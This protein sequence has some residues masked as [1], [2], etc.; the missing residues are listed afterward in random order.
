M[1]ETLESA[2]GFAAAGLAR[3]AGQERGYG[4]GLPEH[5]VKLPGED[6]ALWRCAALR[7]AGF[8]AARVL[9][10]AR[11]AC[12]ADADELLDA[13]ETAGPARAEALGAVNAELDALR[14]EAGWDDKTKRAPL[15][16]ALRLL[17]EGKQPRA[18]GL[19]DAAREALERLRAA[20]ERAEALRDD[21][22]RSYGRAVEE[23][24]LEINRTLEEPRFREAVIWQNRRAFHAGMQSLLRNPPGAGA[25]TFKRRQ[26]EEL[27]ANDL[28]RY[29]VKNDT[30]GFFGPVGWARLASSGEPVRLETGDGLLAARNVYFEGWCID[31][32]ADKLAARA[33]MRPWAAP[34]RVPYMRLEGN[35]L[36]LPRT[37]PLPLPPKYAAVLAACDGRLSA[38]EIAAGLKRTPSLGFRAEAEVYKILTELVGKGLISWTFEIPLE[39]HPEETLRRRLE[40][41]ADESLRAV[42]LSELDELDEARREVARAA[43]DAARLDEA[44]GR[45]EET[46]AR[47]TDA[48]TT[49]DAGKTYAGRTLIYEDCLRD[50]RAEVGPEIVDALGGPLS[51][52]LTSARWLTFKVAELCLQTLGE[53]YEEMAR[54]AASP[55]V[56]AVSFWMR[57][58]P[59]LFAE[60]NSLLRTAERLFQERWAGVLELPPDAGR[61]AY[62]CER[63]RPR[64]LKAFDAPRPGWKLARYHCPDLMIAADDLEAVRRGDYRLVVGELHVGL[65]TLG[66]SLFLSQHPRPAE[67]F[68]ALESDF[69]EPRLMPISPKSWPNTTSRTANLLLSPKDLRLAAAHDAIPEP[70]AETIPFAELVVE[71]SGAGLS[72]RTRDGRL[73]FDLIEAFGDALSGLVV[74]S[75]KLLP[76]GG[77]TPRVTFDRLVVCREAWSF[78]ASELEFAREKDEASSFVAARRWAR[79]HGLPRFVFVKVPVEVKPFY[80]DFDSPVYVGIFARMIRRTA[81]QNS[82]DARVRISEMLPDVLQTWLSDADGQRYTSEIRVVAL[83]LVR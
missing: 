4:A 13:E 27:V 41:V 32:L 20:C 58:Q 60:E 6:W 73:S 44:V 40:Q 49:R 53:I 22:R 28:Q 34:R 82:P 46:F 59:V 8:P 36:H 83:D 42:A 2:D 52:L 61:A 43:G 68:A 56:D 71:K 24:S 78:G 55:V 47:L 25:R 37:R 39:P 9:S 81:E 35:T 17:K 5:L 21:F 64:V 33:G 31:A 77:H 7:G 12:A 70:G 1:D 48:A 19:P 16:K 45:L 10:L 72:A 79:R 38:S 66:S 3:P 50:A 14:L 51:L 30:I 54:E 29:C 65:N 11:P 23:T 69:P 76:P 18:D 75:F 57:A 62:E 63:L 80:L 15:L 74:N 26:N 67:L